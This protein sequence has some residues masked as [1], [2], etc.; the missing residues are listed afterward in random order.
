M[1][2]QGSRREVAVGLVI[3]VALAG[4]F[5][6]L[7]MAGDGPGFLAS[8]RTIDVYFRDG[9]G[10]RE[11]STVRIAGVDAGRVVGVELV[12]V[13]NPP[14]LMA[15]VRLSLPHTLARKLRQ[16]VKVTIQPSLTGQSRVNIVSRGKSDVTLVPGQ[17]VHGVES[18]FFDP[19]LEQVGLGPVERKH[20]SHTIAEVRA[21]VDAT[22]PKV[23]QILGSLQETAGGIRESADLIRPMVEATAAQAEAITK[24]LGASSPKVEAT[25]AKLDSVTARLDALLAENRDNLH[26]TLASLRDLSAT[27]QDAAAKNRP[28]VEQLLVNLDGTRARADRL[29]YQADVI[30]SHGAQIVTK[31][32]ADL[33]RT[34]ANVRDATDWA[35]KLVQKIYANPFVLSPFYKPT[36]E[37]TRAQVVYDSAQ[38]FTK[39]AQELNDLVKTLDA[40][41][42]R[43][44]TPAQQQEVAQLR[45]SILAA[46]ER[47]NQTSQLLADALR[48]PAPARGV[49]R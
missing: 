42:A 18:S 24:R 26:G 43:A 22:A 34:I 46:T 38:V 14:V 44:T 29:L 35:D 19:V 8:H 12:E 28:Q 31:N 9:Q 40:M 41:S 3:V 5:A 17:V 4:I 11:G 13:E 23:R 32:R 47:L 48:R 33:E 49:R 1:S 27:L 6:L 20:L 45:Q 10:I 15:R 25:L 36:P 21:A 2:S 30:A 16:D 7:V 37:D 39:G